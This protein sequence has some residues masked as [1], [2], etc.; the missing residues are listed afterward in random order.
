MAE[1]RRSSIIKK[2]CLGQ[3]NGR[4]RGK[5]LG[6]GQGVQSRHSGEIK[7]G[8]AAA[9]IEGL[10][11]GFRQFVRP[12]GERHGLQIRAAEKRLH[13]DLFGTSGQQTRGKVDGRH[14][15]VGKSPDADP[16]H[17]VRQGDGAQIGAA[18]HGAGQNADRA[19][20]DN[21]VPAIVGIHP[22]QIHSG[23]IGVIDSV[24]VAVVVVVL[25][26]KG[27]DIH[28]QRIRIGIRAVE[29]KSIAIA[30]NIQPLVLVLPPEQAAV[31][32]GNRAGKVQRL[33]F[34]G[35]LRGQPLQIQSHDG[36][37]GNRCRD[38]HVNGVLR[39]L[40]NGNAVDGDGTAVFPIGKRHIF[41]CRE[42]GT[43]QQC[44]YCGQQQ[45]DS[46]CFFH[47]R[48]SF[49]LSEIIRIH[50]ANRLVRP[51]RSC[52][53]SCTRLEAS[54]SRGAFRQPQTNNRANS[55]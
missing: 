44:D 24:A 25:R 48:F 30:R 45:H 10:I 33:D 53:R 51:K 39:G 42:G 6:K 37:A 11:A 29:G 15:A 17:G 38:F 3:V 20:L 8:Q 47:T 27:G 1:N 7:A 26:Y 49:L 54:F 32:P 43:G 19:V 41:L 16:L 21:E 5:G 36:H 28:K 55:S 13:L 31:D 4:S 2:A 46:P 52:F 9:V 14:A 18:L 34:C 12:R 23:V 35:G 22:N 50:I 40:G